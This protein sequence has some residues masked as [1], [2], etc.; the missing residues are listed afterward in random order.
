MKLLTRTNR[1]YLLISMLALA[2]N[3]VALLLGVRSLF[4]HFVDE[5]LTQLEAEVKQYVKKNDALPVFF[6][7]TSAKLLSQHSAGLIARTF[8]DTILF[9]EIEQ[10]KEPFRCLRFAQKINGQYFQVDILQSA[11]ETEDIV[12]LVLLLNLALLVATV[13]VLFWAQKKLSERLWQPFYNTLERLRSF[14]LT[15]ATPL[16][17]VQSD[18][19]EFAELN[20]A[21]GRLTEKARQDYRSLKRFTENASHE[22]Q[23]PL[24]VIRAKLEIL[25]QSEGLNGAQLADLHSTELAATR[26]SRLQQNLLLLVK[27]ENE[28]FEAQEMIPLHQLISSKLELLKDFIEAKKLLVNTECSQV[29]LQLNPFLAETLISNLIGNAVKHN[30]P[31]AGWI[32]VEL[33]ESTLSI[34]N[35]AKSPE[36]PAIEFVERFRRSNSQSE[37]LGLGLAIVA[38]ICELYQWQL[39]V[40][41]ENNTWNTQIAF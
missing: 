17:L 25:I 13:L 11:V 40:H 26:L 7:S 37:G 6:Q 10:E 3:T 18:I 9:N 14:Q 39:S 2:V 16:L 35:S 24:A 36:A 23:T 5:R 1:R 32:R 19:D 28:Q 20:A 22:I 15:Q 29:Q 33:N 30:L 31:K 41:F 21:I 4:D 8:K 27:I 38:E 12:G 34:S